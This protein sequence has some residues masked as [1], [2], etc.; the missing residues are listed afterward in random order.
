VNVGRAVVERGGLIGQADGGTLFLD[1]IAEIP[2][3]QQAHLLRVLDAGT[4]QNAARAL[5]LKSRYALYRLMKK[6]GIASNEE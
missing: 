4:V 3:E 6:H 1:E 2:V 5:G